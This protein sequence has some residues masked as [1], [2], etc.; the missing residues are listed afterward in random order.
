MDR[1]I[2]MASSREARGTEVAPHFRTVNER[3]E[4]NVRIVDLGWERHLRDG[5][6]VRGF[7]MLFSGDRLRV[8]SREVTVWLRPLQCTAPEQTG[9]RATGLPALNGGLAPA[10]INR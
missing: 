8:G 10:L 3:A 6:R 2:A 9:E 7:R 1:P 5:E 4:D